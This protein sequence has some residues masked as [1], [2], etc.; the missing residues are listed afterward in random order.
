MNAKTPESLPNLGPK[1]QDM[2]RRAG[3]TLLDSLNEIGSVSAYVKVKQAG[4]KPSLNFLWGL[5]SALTG[6]HWR[7]VARNHRASLLL[8]LETIEK[9]AQEK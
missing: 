2:L 8:A 5:E 3:I 6:E 7:E 9:A 4:C 1:S